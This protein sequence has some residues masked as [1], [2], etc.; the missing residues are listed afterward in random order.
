MKVMEI[1]KEFF[2]NHTDVLIQF[3]VHVAILWLIIKFI[4]QASKK[5]KLKIQSQP[6]NTSML[7]LL[8][9]LTKII[10]VVAILLIVTSFSM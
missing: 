5:I 1:L 10:K 6:N 8:L 3:V 7:H 4:D 9:A 2:K